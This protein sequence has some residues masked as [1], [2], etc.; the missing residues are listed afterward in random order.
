L[1][2]LLVIPHYFAP[3]DTQPVDRPRYGA[4]LTPL[5]R[6][7][8]IVQHALDLLNAHF[9]AGR[10][11]LDV[12]TRLV[13]KEVYRTPARHH[14]DIVMC[15]RQPAHLLDE[16]HLPRNTR[17]GTTRGDPRQIGFHCH[18]LLAKHVDEYDLFGYLEDDLAIEDPSFFDKIAWFNQTF[19]DEYMLQPNRFEGVSAH[20]GTKVYVDGRIP[21]DGVEIIPNQFGGA[22][23]TASFLGRE[24]AFE[25]KSN[26]MAGGFFMTRNQLARWMRRPGFGVPF[27]TFF[28]TMEC[29]QILGPAQTFTVMKPTG[30]DSDFLEIRHLDPRLTRLNQPLTNLGH[31]IPA[32]ERRQPPRPHSHASASTTPAKVPDGDDAS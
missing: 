17:I 23:L 20:G 31:A 15:V 8:N 2:I 10:Y 14:L 29:A 22:R 3:N 13:G 21:D 5:A 11:E 26:P 4:D 24:I 1:R 18:K 6:R 19:G 32:V 16:L 27:V 12:S 25:A 7:R 30:V 28:G 9:I